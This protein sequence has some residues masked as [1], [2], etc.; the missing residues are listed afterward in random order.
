MWKGIK[1]K[2]RNVYDVLKYDSYSRLSVGDRWLVM[3]EKNN[4]SWDY[5]VYEETGRKVV[6]AYRGDSE[7]DAIAILSPYN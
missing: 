5:V 7:T 4:L 3:E 1:M 6:E 2:N